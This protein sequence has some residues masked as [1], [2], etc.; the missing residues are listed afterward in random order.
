MSNDLEIVL[1]W[2][3]LPQVGDRDMRTFDVLFDF[4][5]GAEPVHLYKVSVKRIQRRTLLNTLFTISFVRFQ[6]LERR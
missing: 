3:L 4:L 1:R 2:R 5:A 6:A